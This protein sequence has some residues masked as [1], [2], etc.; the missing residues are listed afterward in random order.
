MSQ[1]F[2]EEIE[3]YLRLVRTAVDAGFNGDI[4]GG[5]EFCFKNPNNA[6]HLI[7]HIRSKE[8]YPIILWY[9]ILHMKFQNPYHMYNLIKRGNKGELASSIM[10]QYLLYRLQRVLANPE[11]NER[12]I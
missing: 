5:C 2:Q 6:V 11:P 3:H 4:N 10:R 7:G 1:A 8:L 12:V 9:A